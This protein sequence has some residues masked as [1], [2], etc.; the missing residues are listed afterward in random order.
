MENEKAPSFVRGGAFNWLSKGYHYVLSKEELLRVELEN[1]ENPWYSIAHVVELAKR[2]DF[3]KSGFLSKFF[4]NDLTTNA[5]PAA[6]LITGDI[7][8]VKDLEKLAE[9]MQ[10]GSDGFRVYACRAAANSGCMWLVP[11]MLE[12]WHLVEGVDAHENIGYAIA[13]LLDS[14]QYLDDLGPIASRAGSFTY[15]IGRY[16]SNSKLEQLAERA[17]DKNASS[18][19]HDVVMRKYSNLKESYNC[20]HVIVWAGEA[21]SVCGFAKLFL[22][23][24]TSDRFNMTLSPLVVPLRQKFEAVT[25]IDCTMFFQ[26]GRFRQIAA[27]GVLE[28]FLFGAKSKTFQEENRYFFGHLIPEK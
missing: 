8:R 1:D 3:S 13:D 16:R 6:M 22:N 28:E 11:H 9:I 25:G 10:N 12:A 17:R 5:A 15:D 2:G 26:N 24:I 7:G 27:V 18:M 14:I 23:L 19:F 20:D 21:R 4:D